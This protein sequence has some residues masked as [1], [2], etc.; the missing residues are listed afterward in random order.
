MARLDLA[1][2]FFGLRIFDK[3]IVL[4]DDRELDGSNVFDFD[5]FDFA[6]VQSP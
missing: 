6:I 4:P 2:A 5:D 3:L 1:L